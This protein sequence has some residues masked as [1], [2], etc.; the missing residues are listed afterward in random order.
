MARPRATVSR[1]E[2]YYRCPY[3]HFVDY[4]LRPQE[5]RD[6]GEDAM[7]AGTY[8]HALLEEFTA[9][10][11]RQGADFESMSEAQI[12]A[13]LANIAARLRASHNYGIFLQKR[14]AFM[15]KRLREEAGYAM[16]AVRAQFA[17]TRAR[18]AGEEL[19]FG[20]DILRIPTRFGMLTVRGKIYR[21]TPPGARRIANTC[22]SWI[23]RRRAPLQPVGCVLWRG[24]TAR[25]VPHGGG[26]PPGR[27]W[28]SGGTGGRVLLL[29]PPAVSG[30]GRR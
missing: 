13:R 7:Q 8:V 18:V 12:D 25:G 21:W 10:A 4:G 28:T 5:T 15:E 11:Q 6:F 3:R 29:Y 9:E 26:K 27:A 1:L 20:G 17:G 24:V 16:R 22:A 30:G 19:A 23:I 2:G 14:Y